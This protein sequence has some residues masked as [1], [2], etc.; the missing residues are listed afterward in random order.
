MRQYL[1]TFFV[2]IFFVANIFAANKVRIM[3]YNL[4]N[5]G[6]DGY[7]RKSEIQRDPYYRTIIAETDPDIIVFQEVYGR[8]DGE[9]RFLDNVLNHEDN[10]YAVSFIDQKT[11]DNRTDVWQDIGV[12]YKNQMFQPIAI[13]KVEIVGGY[14][15]DAIEVK[16]KYMM[17]KDTI[18]IYGIHLKAG[19]SDAATRE[20]QAKK[21][22]NYL[23]DLPGN[24]P[25]ILAG[26]FNIYTASEGAWKRLTESQ[27]DNDG[28]LF[29]P[30]DQV[31]N[32]HNNSSFEHIHT[33]SSRYSSGGL[34][35]RFDFILISE[36]IKEH[37]KIEYIPGTYIAYGNDGN[38][39][40]SS[41]NWQT[42]SVVSATIADA[43]YE[44]SDH[45][46]VFADFDFTG[47]VG[48]EKSSQP[49]SE[50]QLHQNYPNPFNPQTSIE[51]TLPEKCRIKLSIYDI[52]GKLVKTLAQDTFQAGHYS[53]DWNGLNEKNETVAAGIYYYSL[54]ASNRVKIS[55]KMI[56]LK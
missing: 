33:Q 54:A 29:D 2:V 40:N 50:Y 44:A 10:I 1:T 18:T 13:K 42:N 7:D 9:T 56:L 47:I 11:D 35:D 12:C 21:L 43:L 36:G 34:D 6:G 17:T 45:L 19:Q 5:Y 4:E 14:L 49:I 25:F 23:N 46:P 8:F 55:K 48:V 20:A 24:T 39:F 28:R 3:T 31:G 51:F 32:W 30:I 15:R 27:E 53:L 37:N 38:H 52:Q 16:L 26:D 22:R 41:V